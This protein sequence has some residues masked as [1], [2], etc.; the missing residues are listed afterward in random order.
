MGLFVIVTYRPKRRKEAQLIELLRD[1]VPV[2]RGQGLA[3]KRPAQVMRARDGSIVEVFEWK[4]AEAVKKAHENK[5]VQ[6]MWE[7]FEECCTYSKL[8]D[9]E[10]AG[11]PFAHFE[12]ID[13]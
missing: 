11:E 2:L 1:H 9:L 8:A 7:R 4:S 3:T 6:A 5:V 13:L 12:P 10:E